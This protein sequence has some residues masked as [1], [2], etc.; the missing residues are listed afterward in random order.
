MSRIS[1]ALICAAAACVVLA[2]SQ[3]ATAAPNIGAGTGESVTTAPGQ[4]IPTPSEL[5]YGQALRIGDRLVS[6]NQ[7]SVL[8]LGN[9]FLTLTVDGQTRWQS[10]HVSFLTTAAFNDRM[11]FVINGRDVGTSEYIQ[12]AD[13]ARAAGASVLLRVTD[14]GTV[15]VVSTNAQQKVLWENGT[16]CTRHTM[17]PGDSLQS[18]DELVSAN[19][20]TKLRVERI[21]PHR[22]SSRIVVTYDDK[23]QWQ[24]APVPLGWTLSIKDNNLILPSGHASGAESYNSHTRDLVKKNYGTSVYLKVNADGQAQLRVTESH[25]LIWENGA[26]VNH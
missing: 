10:E 22:T 23:V 2:P 9:G 21:G 12:T 26:L 19:G 5:H 20:R 17:G 11:D 25:L 15:Q 14:A 16:L 7:R 4:L 18:W 24:S 8:R 3:A 13:R 6:P 1:S